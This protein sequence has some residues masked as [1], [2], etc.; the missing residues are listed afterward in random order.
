MKQ[1]RSVVDSVRIFFAALRRFLL[2]EEDS[3]EEWE[4]YRYLYPEKAAA[5]ELIT[6]ECFLAIS[7][8]DIMERVRSIERLAVEYQCS[9]GMLRQTIVDRFKEN[10]GSSDIEEIRAEREKLTCWNVMLAEME[11]YNIKR[12]NTGCQYVQYCLEQYELGIL[13][14]DKFFDKFSKLSLEVDKE[15]IAETIKQQNIAPD[16]SAE[17]GKEVYL[18][19]VAKRASS[20]LSYVMGDYYELGYYESLVYFST[21]LIDLGTEHKNEI[22]LDLLE[23]RYFLLLFDELMCVKQEN[24][25]DFINGRIG[26][27]TSEEQKMNNSDS[28]LPYVLYNAFYVAP[29]SRETDCLQI[30][31]CGKS[32]VRLLSKAIKLVKKNVIF[33]LCAI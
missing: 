18:L 11:Q 25:I 23:D 20:Y 10:V 15:K 29:F 14:G 9:I 1:K 4:R 30:V 28:Y 21:L 17:G 13:K 26:L 6:D 32:K 33:R 16:I 3:K 5:I 27:Y 2:K 24:L 31:S 8:E 12:E 22:N 19:N 7:D